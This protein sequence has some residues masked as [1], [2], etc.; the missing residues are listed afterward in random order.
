ME[1]VNVDMAKIIIILFLLGNAPASYAENL[2]GHVIDVTS[3][4][5]LTLMDTSNKIHKVRLIGIDAPESTQPFAKE[6]R[7]SL[8]SMVYDK[9]VVLI[10]KESVASEVLIGKV[11]QDKKDINLQQIKQGMAWVSNTFKKELSLNDQKVYEKFEYIAK[12]KQIG[13][14]FD[15]CPIEP[16]V[17][18]EKCCPKQVKL[19]SAM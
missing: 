17:F 8:S 12:T 10:L 19:T 5:K 3:G 7:N 2:V 11:L 6:S 4:D 16:W 9:K 14:W 18:R 13:L 1:G 15:R